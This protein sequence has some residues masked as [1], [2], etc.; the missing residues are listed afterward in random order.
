MA[1]HI[2][3]SDTFQFLSE[4]ALN[5]ERRW[6]ND[7]KQR[8]EDLVRTPALQFI[9][10]MAGLL[11]ELSPHFKAIPKKAGGSLMRVYRD[12]RFANDKTPFKTNIGINFRHEAAKDVHAPGYF[13]HIEPQKSFLGLGIWRPDSATLKNIRQCI[14]EN[15]RAWLAAKNNQKFRKVFT[16]AGD[17]LTNP[18]R[19]YAKDHPLLDDLKR[20]DFIAI[21]E[22]DDEVVISG[23]LLKLTVSNFATASPLMR[24]LCYAVELPFD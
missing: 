1:G 10:Q 19:G 24:Y 11:P 14:D 16:M 3:N 6:F 4:L 13:V 17:T 9:Q 12:T 8:Y 20:K 2:F 18:P 23:D 15:P 21:C 22:L 7:N 5:N